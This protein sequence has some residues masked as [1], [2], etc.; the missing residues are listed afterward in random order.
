MSNLI[1]L[2]LI[3][4]E[5]AKIKKRHEKLSYWVNSLINEEV[6]KCVYYH[7]DVGACEESCEVK[8]FKR[9][10]FDSEIDCWRCKKR[11]VMEDD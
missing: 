9:R 4:K 10:D 1:S 11:K 6:Q 2:H 3:A 5:I 8:S 7:F